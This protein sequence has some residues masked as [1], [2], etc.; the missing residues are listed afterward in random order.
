MTEILFLMNYSIKKF[1]RAPDVSGDFD[2]S[3]WSAVK[4]LEI[5]EFHP[6]G[7]DHKPETRVKLA[8]DENSLNMLFN[9]DDQYVRSVRTETHGNVCKDSCVECFISPPPYDV[10]FNFEFNCGGTCL[11]FCV[12]CS[13]D[14][15]KRLEKYVKLDV[16]DIENL[17]IF[18]TM[19]EVVDPEITTPVNWRLGVVVPF[20]LFE[21]YAGALGPISGSTWRANFYKCASDLSHP[22]WASWR[23]LTKKD[24]H[25]PKCFGDLRFE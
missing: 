15:L 14:S 6:D 24:F 7:G 23:P 25:L 13:S 16:A 21:K 17:D 2:G 9:V 20:S 22:H 4:A 11:C 19:P 5:A 3:E 8:W 18:H 10:Y 12:D 1:E